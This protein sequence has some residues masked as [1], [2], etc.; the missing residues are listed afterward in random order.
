MPNK[1][2]KR[3]V[4]RLAKRLLAED[5][6]FKGFSILPNSSWMQGP[7]EVLARAKV[8][9]SLAEFGADAA[10]AIP[11]LIRLLTDDNVCEGEDDCIS[12]WQRTVADSAAA[13]LAHI[14][15]PALPGLIEALASWDH[16]LRCKAAGV[17]GDIGPAAAAAA[18]ALAACV[19]AEPQEVRRNLM[20]QALRKVRGEGR[21]SPVGGGSKRSRN[22]G[23]QA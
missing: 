1:T 14:G 3:E 5:L 13:T 23:K 10:P 9:E 7:P 19:R 8:A 22:R 15:R 18:P 17:L 21:P 12:P 6:A 4:L 20:A 2:S 16:D 11:A